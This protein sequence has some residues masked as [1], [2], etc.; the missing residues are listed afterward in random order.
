MR[1]FLVDEV[2]LMLI[3]KGNEIIMELLQ[4]LNSSLDNDCE[5]PRRFHI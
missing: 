3:E 5:S 2:A 1:E 4:Q